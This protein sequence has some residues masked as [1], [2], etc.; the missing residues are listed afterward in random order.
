MFAVSR[1]HSVIGRIRFLISSIMTINMDKSIGVPCGSKCDNILFVFVVHLNV[2]I[3]TQNISAIGMLL[4]RWEVEENTCGYRA[5]RFI[6][7]IIIKIV[8]M[9]NFVLFLV[10]VRLNIISVF[11]L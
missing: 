11:I 8:M 10:S 2:I 3:D 7:T 5:V 9:I 1:T 6:V 4:I